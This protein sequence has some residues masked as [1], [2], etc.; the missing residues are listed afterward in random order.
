MYTFDSRIRFSETDSE[1]KLSLLGLLNYFQDC[2]TFQSEA[3]GMGLGYMLERKLAWVLS[4]WQITAERYPE[5]GE[6]VTIGT[7]PYRIRGFIGCRNFFMRDSEGRYLA[8]ANSIWALI[9][10]TSGKP[11]AVPPEMYEAYRPEEPLE[12]E[13]ADR[14]IVIPAGGRQQDGITIGPHHLDA[15]RHVNNGQYVAI[16]EDCLNRGHGQVRQL[17]VEYK[18]QAFLGD[19]LYPYL[20]ENEDM[21]FVSFQDGDGKVYAAVEFDT[22]AGPESTISG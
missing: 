14:K 11:V 1:R 15:N 17:R 3:V 12:M 8:K 16:A 13:Y 10:L 6:T 22:T 2:S 18:K 20:V 4:S 19:V 9:D 7:I 21:T 5:L